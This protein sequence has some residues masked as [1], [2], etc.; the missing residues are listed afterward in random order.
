MKLKNFLIASLMAIMTVATFSINAA[1]AAGTYGISCKNNAYGMHL[2]TD[3]TQIAY[4]YNSFE[5]NSR[6]ESAVVGVGTNNGYLITEFDEA[7]VV[8]TAYMLDQQIQT[9][10]PL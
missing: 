4:V 10:Q 8:M 7:Y 2:G 3:Y 6:T 5:R 9:E 1:S